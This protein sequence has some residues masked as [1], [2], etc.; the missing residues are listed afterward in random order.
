V[1]STFFAMGLLPLIEYVFK[2]TTDITLLELSDFNHPLMKELA[3]RAPGTW[4]HSLAVS[5]LSESA[6]ERIGAN[7]LLTR[8][9]S[10]YH[11]IGKISK[12]LYFVEN[13]RSD[14]NP[15]DYTSPSMSALIIESHVKKGIEMAQKYNLPQCIMDFIP[16]HH[17]TSMI[18]FFYDKAKEQTINSSV[19][20]YQYRYTGPKPKSKEAAILMLADSVESISRT[21]K[22]ASPQRVEDMVRAAISSKVE[23]GQLDESDV[24]FNDLRL[25]EKEFVK[26][27]ISTLHHRIEYP[28]QVGANHEGEEK[29]N[30]Q[31]KEGARKQDNAPSPSPVDEKT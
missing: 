1:F 17:G 25:I 5:N 24:T 20:P 10:Y 29:A 26:D 23:A 6:A 3:I 16:Q 31:L 13:Q 22:D 19:D 27:I 11:D 4:A 28:D 9:G 18:S 8:V 7:S 14:Y 21:I 15:H 30:E 2:V 12:P